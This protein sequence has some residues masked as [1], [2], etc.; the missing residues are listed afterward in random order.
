[1]IAPI[2]S[3][4]ASETE[5]QG[6]WEHP[7]SARRIASRTQPGGLKRDLHTIR[8]RVIQPQPSSSRQFSFKGAILLAQERNHIALLAI[9]PS[10]HRGEQYVLRN[11][12]LRVCANVPPKFSGTT[13]LSCRTF[14]CGE[15]PPCR[16]RIAL[17]LL[18]NVLR[19]A[20]DF[21]Y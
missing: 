2:A 8:W 20:A 6:L 12:R 19:F 4:L 7:R 9:E 10:G 16:F 13:R 5:D 11:Q 3:D 14:G 15:P 17:D 18:G 1:V 21:C